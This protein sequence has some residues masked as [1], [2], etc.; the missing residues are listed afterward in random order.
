MI[1]EKYFYISDNVSLSNLVNEIKKSPIIGIDTEFSRSETYFPVL[2][3]IQ[4][5]VKID[6]QKKIFIIDCMR[7]LD[8]SSFLALI[9]D[10]K[11]IKILHSCLQDLQIFF[12]KL[13]LKPQA[14]V[15]TQILAN[16]CDYGT[17]VG[18]GN[19]VEKIFGVVIDKKLQR[20]DWC[21]RPLSEKQLQYA[22]LDV[23]FLHEIYEKLQKILQEK[24]R[25]EFYD[26]EIERFIDKA[27]FGNKDNLIRNFSLRK[28]NQ[29]FV[30][31]LKKLLLWREDQ[32]RIC[33]IPRQHFLRD[34][35]LE[36]LAQNREINSQIIAKINETSLQNLKEILNEENV[37]EAIISN[38][39]HDSLFL[40]SSQ[41]IIFLEAKKIIT[42]I[43]FEVKIAEQFLLNN[44]DLKKII[45]SQENLESVLLK[46]AGKWRFK[47]L[48]Q[49]LAKLFNYK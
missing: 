10:D 47:M 36:E 32:A 18:Y 35:E 12:L 29:Q 17:N 37:D 45:L 7:D 16:F 44:H 41:K 1:D 8:L 39:Y 34:E 43:A 40:S 20:S 38:D 30:A 4:V 48:H 21:R 3:I 11:I 13:P 31:I 5:A 46:I 9:A 49:E 14:I 24:R 2:S 25:S 6:Q 28:K 23:I 27:L 33:D 26:E 22:S 19:L 15:D 42:K